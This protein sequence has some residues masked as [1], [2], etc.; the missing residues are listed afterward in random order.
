MIPR[1]KRDLGLTNRDLVLA[2]FECAALVLLCG[3]IYFLCCAL[4]RERMCKVSYYRTCPYCGLNLDPGEICR[5]Q[6]KV[7]AAASAGTPT[8]EKTEVSN[9]INILSHK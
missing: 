3:S 7:K 9:N 2:T 4:H 1:I 8:T 6:K 5:C